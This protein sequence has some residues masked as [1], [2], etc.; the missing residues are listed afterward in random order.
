LIVDKAILDNVQFLYV[1]Y[2]RPTCFSYEV[3]HKSICTYRHT[4]TNAT[5]RAERSEGDIRIKG[6]QNGAV[7]DDAVRD[8]ER[9]LLR[10]ALGEDGGLGDVEVK[11]SMLLEDM[12]ELSQ[13]L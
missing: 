9:S 8:I 6:S 10:D 7:V 12:L 3:T 2:D 11:S 4:D 13:D 5:F 1:I